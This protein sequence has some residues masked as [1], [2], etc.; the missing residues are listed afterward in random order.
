MIIPLH[1]RPYGQD[2]YIVCARESLTVAESRDRMLRRA[3]VVEGAY[4]F[5]LIVDLHAAIFVQSLDLKADYEAYFSCEY[6]SFAEY[7]RRRARFPSY[8]VSRLTRVLDE[9]TGMYHFRPG[10]TFLADTYGLEFLT[11]LLE[12]SPAGET[13]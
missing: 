6:E 9:S 5:R 2:E 3:K 7:L 12:D 4:A 8:V 10:Y 13:S 11:R 1:S